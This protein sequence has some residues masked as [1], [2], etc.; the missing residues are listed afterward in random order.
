M[1]L[2]EEITLLS[3]RKKMTP[4]K[5]IKYNEEKM[6]EAWEDFKKLFEGFKDVKSFFNGRNVIDKNR[7]G[8]CSYDDPHLRERMWVSVF[9]LYDVINSYGDANFYINGTD[10]EL[11]NIINKLITDFNYFKEYCLKHEVKGRHY[12]HKK[13]AEYTAKHSDYDYDAEQG[14]FIKL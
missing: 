2:R 6:K 4:F 13:A 14:K 3:E 5:S 1:T 10:N 8:W 11:T 12:D 9:K 7:I